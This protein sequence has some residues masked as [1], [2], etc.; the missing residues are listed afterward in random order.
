L[1][2][3]EKRTPDLLEELENVYY[4]RLYI[5]EEPGSGLAEIR[6]EWPDY[7]PGLNALAVVLS[8]AGEPIGQDLFDSDGFADINFDSDGAVGTT[9]FLATV[10]IDGNG[11]GVAQVDELIDLF[12]ADNAISIRVVRDEDVVIAQDWIARRAAVFPPQTLP[13]RF[14]DFFFSNT[15]SL[16]GA[17][18]T[19]PPLVVPISGEPPTMVAG[20]TYNQQTH[21][22]SIPS[23]LLGNGSQASNQIENSFNQQIQ[24]GL[25]QTASSFLEANHTQ[26]WSE[27][28]SSG[29]LERSYTY[30]IPAGTEINLYYRGANQL[31]LSYGSANY[32]GGTIS[33]VLERV[34]N[35]ILSKVISITAEIEDIYDFDFTR[36]PNSASRRG[37]IVQIGWEA[38]ARPTG[39]IF[40]TITEIDVTY[41]AP[42]P[43]DF[44]NQTAFIRDGNF[45]TADTAPGGG[46]TN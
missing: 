23:F 35:T 40:H 27:F 32:V 5:A 30:T 26:I 17:T 2:D 43:I 33:F 18:A 45:V 14:L 44:F 19:R 8:G 24:R 16:N 22:T 41:N 36:A 4:N 28:Q 38:A 10:A 29:D 39:R 37:A 20:S 6:I 46:G 1:A 21:S 7:D 34:D 15:P 12:Q 25:H 31:R 9:L 13:R 3:A 42:A 11:D